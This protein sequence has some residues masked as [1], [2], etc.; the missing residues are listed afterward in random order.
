MTITITLTMAVGLLLIF[1][2]LYFITMVVV[3]MLDRTAKFRLLVLYF[4]MYVLH[5]TLG[6][7]LVI[8]EFTI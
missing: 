3:S 5:F 1:T 6:L 7:L 2:A 8:G 4:T